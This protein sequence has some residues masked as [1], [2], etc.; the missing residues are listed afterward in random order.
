MSYGPLSVYYATMTSG[1]STTSDIVLDRSWKNV[2]LHVPTMSTG[3]ALKFQAKAQISDSYYNI[4]HPVMNSSTVGINPFV[5][6]AV[7]GDGGGVVPIP[8]GLPFMRIVGTGVV[9]GGVNFKII[10]TD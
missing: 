6:S 2:M 7:V 8:N 5:V 10:C 4:Y 1:A 3:V 9:S